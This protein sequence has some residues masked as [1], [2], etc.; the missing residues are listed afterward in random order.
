MK[1]SSQF[2]RNA[3]IGLLTIV[4]TAMP[5]HAADA[6]KPINLHYNERPPFTSLLDGAVV[7][8]VAAPIE[9][10]F[11]KAGIAFK[12]V[13]TPVARQFLLVKSDTGQDCLAGRFKNADRE[14]WA[15][16]SKPVYQD[17]PQGLLVRSDNATARTYTRLEEAVGAPDFRLLVKLSYSY[18]AA[19]DHW[20]AQRTPPARTT[21]DE[22]VDMLRQIKLRMADG[23]IIAAEEAQGLLH[24]STAGGS[25]VK[26]LKFPDS[27][28]GD[29]RYVM[30]SLQVPQA[31][32]DKLNSA[33]TWRAR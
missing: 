13:E 31:T 15:Q 10:A 16:F 18:G 9:N 12:W 33:I 2:G 11:R 21:T 22:N 1:N 23:F 7:G 29:R 4:S 14:T 30:C 24:Q 8:I 26:L 28:E 3:L 20:L 25:D 5:A 17:Q 6:A 32:M 19:V 27:P